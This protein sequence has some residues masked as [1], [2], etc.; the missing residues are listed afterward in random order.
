MFFAFVYII[1]PLVYYYVGKRLIEPAAFSAGKK[2]V[3]WL[4]V[5]IFFL[6]PYSART[7][8]RF[9]VSA[10]WMEILLNIGYI[11]L[12]FFGILFITL[13]TR[14]FILSLVLLLRKM[15][16]AFEKF[17]GKDPRGTKL[18]QDMERRRF[19]V[20]TSN[21]GLLALSG[22]ITGYGIHEAASLP[23]IV[24]VSVPLKNLP[25]D[26]EGFRIVQITDLH[27]GPTIKGK[28]VRGVVRVANELEPDLLAITGDLVEGRPGTLRRDVASLSDLQAKSGKLF[29]TGNHEYY[30]GVKDWLKEMQLL[31][32][33][34]LMNEHLIIERGSSRLLVAG[35]PDLRAHSF[36]PNH[37]PDLKRT[38]KDAPDYH[39][40][41]LL[42]HR[43]RAIFESSRQGF[44]LQL[45]GHTHGGQIYP[46]KYM[47][48]LREPYISG[49][50]RHLKTWIYVSR[51]AGFWGPPMRVG[52]PAEV[53]EITLIKAV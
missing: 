18:P 29:V 15:G 49:L 51:G 50:H 19:L 22:G 27:V 30:H 34:V 24:R 36:D 4:I 11:S 13:L 10:P 35:V 6:L 43:P 38:M 20:H 7:I 46:F 52:A 26:L 53:T 9:D 21:L 42:A 37:A 28:Y 8:R 39:T 41:I 5:L 47:V 14:D 33:Q 23:E 32:F 25:G 31:G 3:A 16:K 48:R 45:S 44:D 40:G 12:G 17:T 1:V 2:A